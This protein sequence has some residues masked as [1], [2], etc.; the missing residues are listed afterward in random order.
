MNNK[1]IENNTDTSEAK[2]IAGVV[3]PTETIELD[4]PINRG[5]KSIAKIDIRK[6]KA[7]ALRGVSLVDVMQMDV[8]A[9]TKVLPRITEPALTALSDFL[10]AK[11]LRAFS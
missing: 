11:K 1:K 10:T 3:T 7:G 8:T 6:P 5:S 2:N 9:L 4:T